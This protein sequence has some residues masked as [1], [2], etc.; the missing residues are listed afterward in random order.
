MQFNSDVLSPTNK[1]PVPC[2]SFPH[3]RHPPRLQAFDSG[4]PAR[5]SSSPK[6]TLAHKPATQT[7]QKTLTCSLVSTTSHLSSIHPIHDGL[8]ALADRVPSPACLPARFRLGNCWK[9][10]VPAAWPLGA[11][12]RRRR[13][14]DPR[15]TNHLPPGERASR[16]LPGGGFVAG[17]V[18]QCSPRSQFL[19]LAGFRCFCCPIFSLKCVDA[20][21]GEKE[22]EQQRA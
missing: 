10:K 5:S 14:R 8:Q 17:L 19:P 1:I 13:R 20:L 6:C 16:R 18:N 7:Q 12:Q 21:G 11:E 9:T 2:A 22:K 3:H 4:L 15:A